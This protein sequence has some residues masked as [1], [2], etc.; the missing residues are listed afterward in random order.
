[1]KSMFEQSL[2]EFLLALHYV[3]P[4]S[5]NRLWPLL[6]CES[7]EKISSM[8]LSK[9]LKITPQKALKLQQFLNAHRHFSF[10]SYYKQ[11]KIIPIT[12]FDAAY[13]K[14]LRHIYDPPSVIYTKGNINILQNERR[15]AVVGSRKATQYSKDALEHLLP[16]LL[17]EEFV[18]VSGLAR[19]ADKMAHDVTITLGGATIG[20]L[21]YGFQHVYPKEHEGLIKVMSQTQL[22]ISEYPPYMGP[23][24]WQFPMRNRL[25]SGISWGILVTEAQKK[26]GTLSTVDYGLEHGRSIF[27]L[28]GNILSPLS[29]LPHKLASEGATLVW[30]GSQILEEMADFLFLK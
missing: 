16:P 8:Q 4:A 26:S 18:V 23:K 30:N 29:E 15:I 14:N 3:M 11:Q 19:G 7:L 28:P 13:P 10:S 2:R 22:L 25:I 1:M 27:G 17:N 5:I 12:F 21:G 9:L 24:K 20:V 6:S